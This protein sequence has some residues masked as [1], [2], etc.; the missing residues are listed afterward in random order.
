MKYTKI[1]F[2]LSTLFIAASAQ[3]VVVDTD[4]TSATY[5]FYVSGASAQTPGLAS[6]IEDF[7]TDPVQTFTDSTDGNSSYLYRCTTANPT[8]SG[9]TGSFNVY[10][11][12]NGSSGGV[13]PVINASTVSCSTTCWVDG[14]TAHV[15]ATPPTGYNVNNIA[16]SV[17]GTAD[18]KASVAFVPQIGMTDVNTGVWAGRGTSVPASS[19][20][21]SL[22]AG[23]QGFG[24]AVSDKLYELLQND[25]QLTTGNAY[26]KQPSLSQAQYAALISGNEGVW[27]KLTP[28][29][30]FNSPNSLPDTLTLARRSTG[31][32]TTA[33]GE[34]FFLNYPCATGS[35]AGG[36]GSSN[37]DEVKTDTSLSGKT[38]STTFTIESQSSS[39]NVVK[40]LATSD[41][42]A[43]GVLSLEN[44]Q[45]TDDLTST[46]WKY[47]KIDG[48][49]PN[50]KKDGTIDSTQKLNTVS[51]Q[52]TFAFESEMLIKL[53]PYTNNTGSVK[54]FAD[55]LILNLAT[56]S[57]L[58]RAT[59]IFASATKTP[60][61][62]RT[63]ANAGQ[64]NRY[65]RTNNAC[66]KATMAWY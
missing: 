18:I 36:A 39:G 33:A 30:A 7:C 57:R 43:I 25:Q 35:K 8:T 37:A 54:T 2:A 21:K 56:P 63:L 27:Q 41:I 17:A 65:S 45:P 51:G 46:D 1:A 24:I 3:A 34:V 10:K 48:V 40:K 61:L 55:K 42:Y 13:L 5:T 38:N 26:D 16:G 23:G 6:S 49:S 60:A 19:N 12:D 52:Y 29:L 59:G 20:F 9:L 62:V 28:R 4:V 50:I 22:Y 64:I 58:E 47:V 14:S 44:L 31:S 66:K 15:G 53:T 11:L 32:G